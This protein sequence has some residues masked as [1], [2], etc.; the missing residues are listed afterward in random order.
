M[1][2]FSES[3]L[4]D[5]RKD[6]HK[7][8]HIEQNKELI[9][10]MKYKIIVFMILLG[11]ILLGTTSIAFA[12]NRGLP[13]Q[14]EQS[15]RALTVYMTP[16]CGCCANHAGY[17]RA[18]KFDVAVVVLDKEELGKKKQELGIPSYLYSC[19]TT[20]TGSGKYFIEGHMPYEAIEK[21]LSEKPDI[22]GISLPGMPSASPGMPGGKKGPF[23]IRQVP[24][25]SIVSVFMSL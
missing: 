5:V 22:L 3:D 19:H 24:R 14:M 20:V 12:D 13:T 17:L 15:P 2:E 10:A 9:S 18:K 21:L 25:D 7:D 1:A 8:V 6:I 23:V 16:D 11:T 4:R